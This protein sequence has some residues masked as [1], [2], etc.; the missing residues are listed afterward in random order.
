M[1]KFVLKFTI[2]ERPDPEAMPIEWETLE[3]HAILAPKVS[4][5]APRISTPLSKSEAFV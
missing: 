1:A 2:S 4:A 3:R 5:D